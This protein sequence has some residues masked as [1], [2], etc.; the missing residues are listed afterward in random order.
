MR[1]DDENKIVWCSEELVDWNNSFNEAYDPLANQLYLLARFG[2]GW[3]L[4]DY[5]QKDIPFRSWDHTKKN[6]LMLALLNGYEFKVEQKEY[7]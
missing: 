7:Y 5:W 1:I 3:G 4:V 2:F 6:E